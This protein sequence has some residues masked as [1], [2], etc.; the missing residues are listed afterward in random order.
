MLGP[1]TALPDRLPS[2]HRLRSL[3]RPLRSLPGNRML[4]PLPLQRFLPPSAEESQNML[5]EVKTKAEVQ[6][7]DQVTH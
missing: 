2:H 5:A 4:D 7:L 1:V 3:P 6:D